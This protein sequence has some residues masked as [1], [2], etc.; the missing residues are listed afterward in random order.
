MAFFISRIMHYGIYPKLTKTYILERISQEQI[1]EKYLGIPL[2]FDNQFC[3]PLRID[4]NPTCGLYYNVHGRLRMRDLS[5]HF[6]GDCFDLVAFRLKLNSNNKRHFQVILHTIAKDF[7]IHKYTDSNEVAN[8]DKLFE[9]FTATRK[10]K[11]P[12]I[13]KIT[14]RKINGYDKLYWGNINVNEKLLNYGRVYFAQE[15]YISK[16]NLPFIKV[17]SYTVKDPAYCYYGG[18][19]ENGVDQWKIYFPYRK[20]IGE[21]GFL[22][23]SSFLQGR[24][25]ITCGRFGGITK[26]YKDVLSFLSLGVQSVAPTGESTPIT[27]EEYWFMRTKFDYLFSCMDYDRA[28]MRMAQF[29]RKTYRIEPIMFTNGLYGSKDFGAKVLTDNMTIVG[30]DNTKAIVHGVYEQ[31]VQDFIDLDKYYYNALKHIK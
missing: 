13:I 10:K 2:D 4:H 17:Y 8:Y 29:L 5:G 23:N 28:G 9:A 27:P 19:F 16:N 22:S 7:R 30:I 20:K 11:Y 31:Y 6:W 25:L 14:P 3:S 1:M 21:N 18:K 12:T 15:I 24:H 26:S